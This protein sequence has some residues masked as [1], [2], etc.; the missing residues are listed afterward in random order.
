MRDGRRIDLTSRGLP[1]LPGDPAHTSHT[2]IDPGHGHSCRPPW[3]RGALRGCERNSGSR[4]T[5]RRVRARTETSS[6]CNAVTF[7]APRTPAATDVLALGLWS[8]G[9]GSARLVAG[10]GGLEGFCWWRD[11]SAVRA[12]GRGRLAAGRCASGRL[13]RGRVLGAAVLGFVAGG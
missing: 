9:V 13:R 10:G 5:A 2:P 1:S 8:R 3:G 12:G 4:A 7:F 6:G 11:A